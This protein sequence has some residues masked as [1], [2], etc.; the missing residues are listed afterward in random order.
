MRIALRSHIE[1]EAPHVAVDSKRRPP[2]T[3]TTSSR[4]YEGLVAR[5]ALRFCVLPVPCPFR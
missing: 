2:F 3:A 5:A 4:K 1:R